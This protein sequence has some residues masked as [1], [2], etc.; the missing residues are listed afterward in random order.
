MAA[1]LYRL[2]VSFLTKSSSSCVRT[3]KTSSYM[4]SLYSF[5]MYLS[6]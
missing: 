2:S 1:F 3:C 5:I 6:F 4:V